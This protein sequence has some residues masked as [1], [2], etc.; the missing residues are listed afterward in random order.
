MSL[1]APLNRTD[2]PRPDAVNGPS[3]RSVVYGYVDHVDALSFAVQIVGDV[4]PRTGQQRPGV[5]IW[6][7]GIPRARKIGDPAHGRVD[8]LPDHETLQPKEVQT[9]LLRKVD[10]GDGVCITDLDLATRHGDGTGEPSEQLAVE[11][12]GFRHDHSVARGC[13]EISVPSDP[14]HAS[15]APRVHRL[16]D[17]RRGIA[18]HRWLNQ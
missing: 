3:R 4:H 2:L 6:A 18:T 10:G 14:T 8:A 12:R 7:S 13:S 15:A 5:V 1:L 11:W 9:P 17:S 16:P